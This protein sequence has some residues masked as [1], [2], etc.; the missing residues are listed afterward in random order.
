MGGVISLWARYLIFIGNTLE[1]NPLERSEK[2]I[3]NGQ[4]RVGFLF[5]GYHSSF[6]EQK[7]GL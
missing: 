5:K 1:D 7:L 3:S 6:H 4:V 2:L